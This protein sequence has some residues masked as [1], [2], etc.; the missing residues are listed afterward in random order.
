MVGWTGAPPHVA[1]SLEGA[2]DDLERKR[3]ECN[4]AILEAGGVPDPVAPVRAEL[5]VTKHRVNHLRVISEKNGTLFDGPM[6]R[7]TT[8]RL[9]KEAFI[10]VVEQLRLERPATVRV[11]DADAPPPL[12][13]AAGETVPEAAQAAESGSKLYRRHDYGNAVIAFAR[14]SRV[15][16][17]PSFLFNLGLC[18]SQLDRPEDAIAHLE[19]YLERAPESAAAPRARELVAALKL[20]LAR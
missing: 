18:F 8:F 19:L 13:K 10:R 7:W 6:L 11:V 17:D 16:R 1:I 9:C 5:T 14:A 15:S 2:V 20:R 3:I 4:R 12:E